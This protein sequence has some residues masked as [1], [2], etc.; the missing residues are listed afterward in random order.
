MTQLQK[1]AWIELV[2]VSICTLV[3]S[4]IYCALISYNVKGLHH[5]V[6]MVVVGGLAGTITNL[7][8]RRHITKHFD[9]RE[10]KIYVRAKM[11][12][13]GIFLLWFAGGCFVPFFVLGSK[14]SIPVHIP[15]VFFLLGIFIAQLVQS[16]AILIRCSMESDDVAE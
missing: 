14:S 8:H 4:I 9:E 5:I 10:R 6:I 11:W 16:A 12:G 3:A 1:N 15:P 7:F 13:F 2:A